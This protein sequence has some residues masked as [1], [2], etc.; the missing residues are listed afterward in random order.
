MPPTNQ[1]TE[2]TF[3]ARANTV[4]SSLAAA[5]PAGCTRSSPRRRL[6]AVATFPVASSSFTVRGNCPSIVMTGG[7][8]A[9]EIAASPST[10]LF[11]DESTVSRTPSSKVRMLS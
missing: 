10:I 5:L 9:P 4:K 7:F 11:T 8:G 1:N 2:G 3:Q 6:R